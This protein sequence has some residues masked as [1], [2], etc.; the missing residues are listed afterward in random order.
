MRDGLQDTNDDPAE[1]LCGGYET[2]MSSLAGN[3]RER[4][5]WF[6]YP[7]GNNSVCLETEARHPQASS[8]RARVPGLEPALRGLTAGLTIVETQ[9]RCLR[10]TERGRHWAWPI[11]RS[12]LYRTV[13]RPTVGAIKRLALDRAGNGAD[14]RQISRKVDACL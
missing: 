14:Q 3:S 10:S 5:A 9:Y 4:L 11:F 1:T 13:P 7:V 8:R 12:E 2:D 6:S